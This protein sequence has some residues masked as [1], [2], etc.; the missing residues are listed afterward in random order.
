M[1][2]ITTSILAVFL[3][4]SFAQLQTKDA[5][6]SFFSE[7]ESIKAE[8]SEVEGSLDVST[9]ELTFTVSIEKFIFP[10]SM[11]QKHFN[12]EGVMN[13]IEFPKANYVGKIVNNNTVDYTADGEY[14]VTV[15]GKMTIKGVSKEFGADG[16]IVVK[17]GQIS[18][19]ASFSLDRFEYGVDSKE[20]SVSQILAIT[21]KADFK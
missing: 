12:Q 1:K 2:L 21:V 5:Y 9:G 16:K 20:N 8:N 4:I 13:S 18:A 19:N 6:I 11:M 7:K 15:K 10:N 14:N 17:N 3:S